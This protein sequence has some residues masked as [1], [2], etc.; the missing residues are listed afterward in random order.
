MSSRL[1]QGAWEWQTL[2]LHSW[3]RCVAASPGGA[4]GLKMSAL[5]T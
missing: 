1:G 3:V 2:H 4:A 5:G